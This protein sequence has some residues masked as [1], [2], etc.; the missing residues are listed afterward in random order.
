MVKLGDELY[1][2]LG[3]QATTLNERP[4][5]SEELRALFNMVP[6]RRIM[7]DWARGLG[8]FTLRRYG[9]VGHYQKIEARDGF[10]YEVW[11]KALQQGLT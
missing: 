6:D 3:A 4:W 11:A 5:P 7:I 8:V 1:D 2:A 10:N 9:Q